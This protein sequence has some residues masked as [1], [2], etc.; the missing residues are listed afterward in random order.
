[1]RFLE[2]IVRWL[3]SVGAFVAVTGTLLMMMH[4]SADVIW[5]ALSGARLPAT[6]EIVSKYYMV[7]LAFLPLGWTE[8]RRGMITV[9]LLDPILRASRVRPINDFLIN[10][11]SVLVYAGL[12]YTTWHIAVKEFES[13]SFVMAL[14]TPV[15]VWPGYFM[16]PFGF[17]LAAVTILLRSHFDLTGRTAT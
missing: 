5:R 8:L 17:A 6:V 10:V 1:M 12:T 7:I 11:V 4:I 13:G 16:L 9:D 15:P 14:N 2:N 3:T